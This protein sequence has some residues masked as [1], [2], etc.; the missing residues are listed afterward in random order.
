MALDTVS[1]ATFKAYINLKKLK[2][3]KY[4]DTWLMKIVINE[5]LTILKKQKK[6]I[7]LEDYKKD[8]E[9]KIYRL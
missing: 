6:V 2:D 8:I 5:A 1:E 9:I 3:I 4:F 7:H